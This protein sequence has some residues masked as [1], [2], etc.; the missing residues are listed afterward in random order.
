MVRACLV[1]VTYT[2]VTELPMSHREKS[3][4]VTL[5]ST[6]VERITTGLARIH[7]IW[8]S[9][10]E[11]IVASVLLQREL[12]IVCLVPFG[13]IAC[14]YN[15]LS[16]YWDLAHGLILNSERCGFRFAQ[17]Q[18]YPPPEG[19]GCSDSIAPQ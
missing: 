3:A 4:A 12:G 6:D 17:L 10:V 2:K 13:V 9:I 15:K 11:L 8:A 1:S 7:E 16:Q 19:L 14:S 5:M 18:N